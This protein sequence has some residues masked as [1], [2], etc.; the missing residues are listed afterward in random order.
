MIIIFENWT[1]VKIQLLNVDKE[2]SPDLKNIEKLV[3][4]AYLT[5]RDSK[6]F[7]IQEHANQAFA[8]SGMTEKL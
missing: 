4:A 1:E 3:L 5:G 8:D 6:S 7:Q 2:H